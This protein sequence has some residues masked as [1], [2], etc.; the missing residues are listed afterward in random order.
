MEKTSVFYRSVNKDYPV[1]TG[2]EGIF[3][4]DDS[5]NSYLDGVSGCVVTNIGYG[6]KSVA[7]ALH[8]EAL[9]IG[10]AHGTLFTSKSQEEFA[11]L[12]TADAPDELNHAYLVS[13]GTEANET[14]FSIAIQYYRLKGNTS[15]WKFIGR[16]LSYHGSSFATMSAAGNIQRRRLYSPLVMPFPLVPAPNCYRCYCELTYPECN[17]MCAHELE[18]TILSEGAQN[19]AGFILEPVIG[20]SAAGSVP[21]AEYMPLV[22]DI[23]NRYDVL[24]IADEVLC[25]YGRSGRYLAMDHWKVSADLV[26]LGKGLGGGYTP[27]GAVLAHDKIY[28]TF[29][30]GTGDFVHGYTY[31]GNPISCAAGIA[32]NRYIKENKLFEQVEA[33]GV[34]LKNKMSE[35]AEKWQI[36]GDVRG[37]G[38]LLGLELVKNRDTR[39]SYP[40]ETGVAEKARQAAREQGLL[41]YTGVGR[42]ADIVPRDYLLVAPPFIISTEEMDMLIE[43]LDRAMEKVSSVL[44]R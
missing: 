38:L 8:R 18:K 26:T 44:D 9:E 6:V 14:A 23:C 3:V 33:K 20:T 39:E 43:R 31:Q 42:T 4:Q 41:L 19:I 24:L 25:G 30:G 11:R 7:A 2:G 27:I 22:R 29:K 17:I 37:I 21:P 32:V 5:G 36:I 10:Y 28:D 35:I 1:I 40:V 34:Y 15:K 13:G 12:I 16:E